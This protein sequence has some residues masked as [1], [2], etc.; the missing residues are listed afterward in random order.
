MPL[1]LSFC[2]TDVICTAEPDKTVP[3]SGNG[4][5]CG[6]D[7]GIFATRL[8]QFTIRVKVATTSENPPI[9]IPMMPPVLRPESCGYDAL[10]ET[11]EDSL[12]ELG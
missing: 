12:N 3:G 11:F 4:V 5:C 8:F 7:R 6:E 10:L 1:L 9:A 2:C